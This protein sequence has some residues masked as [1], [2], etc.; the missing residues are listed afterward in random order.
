MK[1]GKRENLLTVDVSELDDDS[2]AAV[3]AQVAE[4]QRVMRSARTAGEAEVVLAPSGDL[5]TDDKGD[6]VYDA[7]HPRSGEFELVHVQ[8]DGRKRNTGMVSR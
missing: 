5:V 3:R 8:E 2:A 6:G 1:V 4:H 7:K